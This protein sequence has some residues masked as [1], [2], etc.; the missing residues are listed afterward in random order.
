MGISGAGTART[1]RINGSSSINTLT[2]TIAP[3]H[4]AM[5]AD[6]SNEVGYV[7]GVIS[8]SA[9]RSAGGTIASV[10]TF[11]GQST[12]SS[13]QVACGYSGSNF[14]ADQMRT[15][16]AIIYGYLGGVGAF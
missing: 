12:Y 2:S 3:G 5:A 16:N 7:N 14:T 9:A 10:L 11:L 15:M 4:F 13:D 6:T 8:V 1:A